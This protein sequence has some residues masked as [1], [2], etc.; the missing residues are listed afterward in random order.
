MREL[1]AEIKDS[2]KAILTDASMNVIRSVSATSALGSIVRSET[3]VKV[4]IIDGAATSSLIS[5]CDE[6]GVAYLAAR[7]FSHVE[8]TKVQLISL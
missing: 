7:N 3:P 1:Y 8:G 2:K 6:N 5:A 4:V